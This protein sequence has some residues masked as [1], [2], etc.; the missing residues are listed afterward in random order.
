MSFLS[1]KDSFRFV[2]PV[3]IDAFKSFIILPDPYDRDVW[4]TLPVF[5]PVN[6]G[7]KKAV[8]G[9][10]QLETNIKEQNIRIFLKIFKN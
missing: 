8:P 1:I 4:Y 7:P 3:L 2:T 10:E 6:V 5:T 9:A